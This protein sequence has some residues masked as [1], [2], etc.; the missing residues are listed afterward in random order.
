MTRRV[1][2]GVLR[3]IEC[4]G[5][6]KLEPYFDDFCQALAS[7]SSMVHFLKLVNCDWPPGRKLSALL[8]PV[9][10]ER[11][12]M[13]LTTLALFDM[14]FAADI[15]PLGNLKRL[16]ELWIR[17]KRK[18]PGPSEGRE[19]VGIPGDIT[20][21]FALETLQ[22][23]GNGLHGTIPPAFAKLQ[24]LQV[25]L[26]ILPSCIIS[27]FSFISFLP[28]FFPYF[29]S[30]LRFRSFLSVFHFLPSL[31][32]HAGHVCQQQLSFRQP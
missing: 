16:K 4:R 11:L 3:H 27:F 5:T 9:V 22:I 1:A 23:Y 14:D 8:T 2:S 21:L 30:F 18:A 19:G 24:K 7:P 32:S 28:S 25:F 29:F 17:G 15:P 31:P 20:K 10:T 6:A 26:H 12:G 13:H